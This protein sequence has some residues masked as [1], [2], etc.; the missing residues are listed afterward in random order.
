MW[1]MYVLESYVCTLICPGSR[2]P[3][4]LILLTWVLMI[5]PGH[6]AALFSFRVRPLQRGRRSL[7]KPHSWIVHVTS[8]VP[9]ALRAR[10]CMPDPYQVKTCTVSSQHTYVEYSPYA[11]ATN[12][13]LLGHVVALGSVPKPFSSKSCKYLFASKIQMNPGDSPI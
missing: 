6:L 8:S 2:R 12:S 5:F 4:W 9:T 3:Y 1:C 7:L 13:P 10:P 11:G